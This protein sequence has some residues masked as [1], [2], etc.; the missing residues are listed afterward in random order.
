MRR[1]LSTTRTISHLLLSFADVTGA[2]SSNQLLIFSFFFAGEPRLVNSSN[3][4]YRSSARSTAATLNFSDTRSA[5]DTAHYSV[6]AQTDVSIT[7]VKTSYRRWARVYD[8]VF[9]TVLEDGRRKML[10]Q[11]HAIHPKTLL[12]MGVGTGLL[13]PKYPR[14]T[15]VIGVDISDDMLAL[16]QQKINQHALSNATVQLD[17]CEHLSFATASFD[18]VV[19]PYILSVTPNPRALIDEALRVCKPEG[20]IIIAN[21]FS[22]SK[23]WAL[24]EKIAAP[25]AAKI[26]FRSSFSYAE[27]IEA[28]PLNVVAVERANLLGLSKVVTAKR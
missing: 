1:R 6:H 12:E 3:R 24:L 11:V 19:L 16:A 23:T 2:H 8:A 10:A 7:D 17:D 21:H 15:Q 27:H 5:S 25:T 14:E 26:G 22:G 9:G 13:L 20:H 28:M 4:D 18:C